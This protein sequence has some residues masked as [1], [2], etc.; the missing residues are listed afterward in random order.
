[1][2]RTFDNGVKTFLGKTGAFGPDEIVD[3]IVEQPA[4]A[5]YIT[6]RLAPAAPPLTRRRRWSA[7]KCASA[8]SC[9]VPGSA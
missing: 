5:E 3:I 8:T 1:T 2:P 9:A 4:S 7:R 6:R